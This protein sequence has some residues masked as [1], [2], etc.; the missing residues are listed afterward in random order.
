MKSIKIR[1]VFIL[2]VVLFSSNKVWGQFAPGTDLPNEDLTEKDVDMQGG[3]KPF[4]RWIN[5]AST[6]TP[7][8]EFYSIY[9][10]SRKWEWNMKYE[11]FRV[12][13]N[14]TTC[15]F[16]ANEQSG[17]ALQFYTID[18]KWRASLDN[19]NSDL[20]LRTLGKLKIV[21]N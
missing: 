8:S 6:H 4:V 9:Y 3:E 15:L 18:K 11:L 21:T 20:Y 2:F 19:I 1:F 10:G 12:H 14:G 17:A 13:A 7:E 16:Q 5:K